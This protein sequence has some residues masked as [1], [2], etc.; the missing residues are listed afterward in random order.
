M[1]I[2]VYVYIFFILFIYILLPASTNILVT[3]TGSH[4]SIENLI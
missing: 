4:K 1:S 3:H 2:K